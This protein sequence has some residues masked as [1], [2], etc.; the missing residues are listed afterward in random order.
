MQNA[1]MMNVEQA[2]LSS[3]F[4][5]EVDTTENAWLP[6]AFV[7]LPSAHLLCGCVE[8]EGVRVALS[9]ETSGVSGPGSNFRHPSCGTR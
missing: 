3:S 8:V 2:V 4:V 6:I 5:K 7:L 1:P 9:A